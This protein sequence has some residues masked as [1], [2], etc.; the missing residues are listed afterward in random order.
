MS[1]RKVALVTAGSAGLG[2]AIA[3]VL[4]LDLGMSVTINYSNN[5]TRAEALVAKFREA[6]ASRPVKDGL[7]MPVFRAIKADI[8]SK[9][10][11]RRLV[12]ETTDASG[13]RLD[14]VI[15][16][17]GWTQIRNFSDLD[18]GIFEDDWDRCYNSNVKSHLWLFHAARKHLEEANE[19]EKGSAVFVSTASIAGVKPSGSSLPYAV[20][21][22]AQIHLMKSLASICAPSIRV[23]SVSPG[24]LLTEWGLSFP[25]EKIAEA[26]ETNKLK[27]IATVEDVAEHVRAFVVSNSVTGQNSIID[28]GLSL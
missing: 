4:A 10:E 21:K 23:N 13:G 12:S 25:P 2:A 7:D 20:S 5:A 27:T 18:D 16:N 15:S 26:K 3:K 22:A 19:R 14:V 24:L 6:H 9:D 11:I 1:S 8:F 17:A 28:A